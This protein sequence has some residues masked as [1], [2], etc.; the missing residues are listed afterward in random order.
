M[1]LGN[2]ILDSRLGNAVLSLF[3]N[4]TGQNVRQL[5]RLKALGH[6]FLPS[7]TVKSDALRKLK[8]LNSFASNSREDLSKLTPEMFSGYLDDMLSRAVKDRNAARAGVGNLV[9]TAR[10]AG[11]LGYSAARQQQ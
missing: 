7:P 10:T 8:L 9:S 1:A 2:K 3:P 4:I 11:Q 6:S 5:E